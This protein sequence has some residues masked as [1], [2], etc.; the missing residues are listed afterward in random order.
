MHPTHTTISMIPTVSTLP[1]I[2]TVRTRPMPRIR[3][4]AAATALLLLAGCTSTSDAAPR[5]DSEVP[6]SEFATL[7]EQAP[8]ASTLYT[9]ARLCAS[10]GRDAQCELVLG[11]LVR[12]HPGFAPGWVD[13]AELFVRGDR[14]DDAVRTLEAARVHHPVDVVIANDLGVCQL[15]RGRTNEALALFTEAAGLSP[16]DAR[17]RANMAL[18][19]GLLGRSEEAASLYAQFLPP[20]AVHRN[21]AIA[22]EARGD[23]AGAAQESARAA[24]LEEQGS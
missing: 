13:L 16:D 20:S 22:A 17:T 18:A 3:A 6:E 19:L 8:S 4:L 10:Q 9:M 2:P 14:V 5:W 7:G 12:A 21:L 1:T 24:E 23:E 11:E 15:L